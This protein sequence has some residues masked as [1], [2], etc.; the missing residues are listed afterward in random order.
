MEKE[1]FTLIEIVMVV[2]ILGILAAVLIPRAI[3]LRRDAK[4]AT[5]KAS[6]AAIR[7]GININH[8]ER[9]MKDT[10]PPYPTFSEVQ[11]TNKLTDKWG[12]PVGGNDSLIMET[13][14]LPDNPFDTDNDKDSLT[15]PNIGAPKGSIPNTSGGWVYR[16]SNGEVWANTNTPGVNEN[17]F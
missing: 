17:T 13:G 9:L 7:D 16:A 14:D 8:T 12:N 15:V 1:G 4:I 2:L 3:D 5:C 10:I 11:E 6:L